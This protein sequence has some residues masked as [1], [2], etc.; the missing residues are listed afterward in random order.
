MSWNRL[1]LPKSKGGMGFRNIEVFNTA[2]LAKQGWRILQAQ[3]SLVRRI[4]KEKY[5]PQGSFL[6]AQLG[7]NPSYACLSIFNARKVLERGLMWRVGNGD[8]IQIWQDKWIPKPTTYKIR[9]PE[10]I[11]LLI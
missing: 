5:F 11:L 8:N 6:Q 2:L 10:S 4:L 3:D 9:W 1:G 7:R